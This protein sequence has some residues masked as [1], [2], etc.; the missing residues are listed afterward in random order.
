MAI[1]FLLLSRGSLNAKQFLCSACENEFAVADRSY[2]DSSISINDCS[3]WRLSP[4]S[5]NGGVI[6]VSVSSKS[7][8]I[9]SSLFHHCFTGTIYDGG[10][11]YF[12]S[13]SSSLSMVCA[14]NCSAR[15]SNFA[16][17]IASGNNY[18]D[19]N[20]VGN[21]VGYNDSQRAISITNG[22]IKVD[23]S[24]FSKNQAWMT[25]TVG[26][27]SPSS[28]SSRYNSY[29]DNN[30]SHA[31]C[32]GFWWNSGG[33]SFANVIR[34]NSPLNYG[35][36]LVSNMGSYSI[37]YCIFYENRDSLFSRPQG[38][39]TIQH[40]FISHPGYTTSSSNNSIGAY[41]SYAISFFTTFQCVD[42]LE[43]FSSTTP[44]P[45][46]SIENNSYPYR[47]YDENSP[48]IYRTYDE[49]TNPN[50][51][52]NQIISNIRILAITIVFLLLI[53]ILLLI[54]LLCKYGHTRNGHSNTISS[55][56]METNNNSKNQSDNLVHGGN[57]PHFYPQPNPYNAHMRNDHQKYEF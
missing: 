36:I 2:S 38:T 47:T 35:V 42:D 40:N 21:I 5:G 7:Q 11:I 17:L 23:R 43:F 31:N 41:P 44:S 12:N 8:T 29:V 9:V 34:N 54:C 26:F 27:G 50:Q 53:I 6:F 49:Q 19:L 55:D 3:F 52:W 4:F 16:H 57:I 32:I 37:T 45:T 56:E 33:I 22:N 28:L 15:V 18:V 10:A 51:I 39:F 1:I 13:A 25:T 30:A 24:N 48:I 46:M 14:T 20:T